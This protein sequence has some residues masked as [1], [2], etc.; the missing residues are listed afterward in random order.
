MGI[1]T[2]RMCNHKWEKT[3]QLLKEDLDKNL[4]EIGNEHPKNLNRINTCKRLCTNESTNATIIKC[5]N[6]ANDSNNL[7]FYR[8]YF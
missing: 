6:S 4:Q 8:R 5:R 2:A 3:I 1:T 7:R